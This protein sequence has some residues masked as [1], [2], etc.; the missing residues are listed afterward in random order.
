MGGFP[1]D[2]GAG[3]LESV[4]RVCPEGESSG[5][6]SDPGC[7]I[8]HDL[9]IASN[10]EHTDPQIGRGTG[11]K[12]N[13]SGLGGLPRDRVKWVQNAVRTLHHGG[14]PSA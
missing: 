4:A 5:Y 1:K 14:G 9:D 10:G 7:I 6:I 11:V 8:P 2:S 12:V 3:Q 13:T